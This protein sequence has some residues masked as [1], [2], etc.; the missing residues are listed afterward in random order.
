MCMELTCNRC[1]QTVQEGDC[2]C[3][4]CGLPQIVY[5]TDGAAVQGEG[6]HRQERVLDAGTVD[7]KLA[8]RSAMAL[9][10]PAGIFCSVPSPVGFFGLLIMAGAAAWVVALYLRSRRPGWITIGAGARIGLVTGILGSWTAAVVTALTLYILRFL[11]HHGDVFDNFWQTFCQQVTQQ[12]TT[13]G[14]D[15]QSMTI[16]KGLLTSPEGR[17]GWV[18]AAVAFLMA[19]LLVFATAGGAISAHLLTRTRRS[20]S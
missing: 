4:V 15:S 11:L 17:A 19:G 8:L 1:H 7:W 9:A 6:E 12:W 3:P 5:S 20:H 18:L 14:V 16:L 13:M 2:Y 10:I